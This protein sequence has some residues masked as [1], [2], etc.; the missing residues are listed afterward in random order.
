MRNLRR[1]RVKAF[2]KVGTKSCLLLEVILSRGLHH[3]IGLSSTVKPG[4]KKYIT[5]DENYAITTETSHLFT[6]LFSRF[7]VMPT[8]FCDC[9]FGLCV[10]LATFF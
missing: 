8:A 9:R 3:R 4:D 5:S 7:A 6:R 10:I 1:F 2:M